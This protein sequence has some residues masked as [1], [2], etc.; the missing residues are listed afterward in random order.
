MG[1]L[2]ESV[3]SIYSKPDVRN[4]FGVSSVSHCPRETFLNYQWFKKTMAGELPKVKVDLVR[5][6]LLNDGHYQEAQIVDLIRRAGYRVD[7]TGENQ[8]EVLIGA[9]KLRGHP[10]GFLTYIYEYE[11]L[12]DYFKNYMSKTKELVFGHYGEVCNNCK[13]NENLV[14]DHI[15]E[16]G[17]EFRD[18]V[19]RSGGSFYHWISK[20]NYPDDL[21]VLCQR[22][23]LNKSWS[24]RRDVKVFMRVIDC[25]EE[26]LK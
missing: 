22:C 8:S 12:S 3:L 4:Y 14:I 13:T 11:H 20:N 2:S 25:L 15:V 7:K 18:K 17:K 10:D 16:D 6:A 5:Q 1:F 19:R 9:S 23:N 26:Y 24:I 21:Q